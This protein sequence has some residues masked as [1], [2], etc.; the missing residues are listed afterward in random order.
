[1]DNIKE[2]LS[3]LYYGHGSNKGQ[4]ALD[5]FA[6]DLKMEMDSLLYVFI[7]ETLNYEVDDN[8]IWLF[9]KNGIIRF[10]RIDNENVYKIIPLNSISNISLFFSRTRICIEF[11]YW[12]EKNSLNACSS[13]NKNN[14]MSIYNAL[15]NKI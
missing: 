2:Y 6:S 13:F 14:L 15:L 9:T 3:Q 8:T 4:I 1:M 7:P 12:G 11:A 5:N 10:Q